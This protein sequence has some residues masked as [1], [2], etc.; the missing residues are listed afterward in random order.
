MIKFVKSGLAFFA[1]GTTAAVLHLLAFGMLKAHLLPE[2]ANLLAYLLA[3]GVSFA[4]HRWISF[5]GAQT[6]FIESLK[7][8]AITSVAGFSSNQLLFVIFYRGFDVND[9]LA[10]M[11]A[12]GLAAVQ[13]FLLSRWWA[14][15]V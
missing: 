12:L 9:W 15:K 4:G 2:L 14:F 8:F 11:L 5:Q 3:F 13:T 7:R 6:T 1:V 10:L